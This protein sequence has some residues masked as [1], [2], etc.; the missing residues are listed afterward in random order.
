MHIPD[1]YLGPATYGSF[2]AVMVPVWGY[3]SKKV[4]AQLPSDRIPHLAM[5]SVF[6]LLAMTFAIPVPGGTTTHLQGA[7]LV[8]ILLGPW[9]AVIAVSVALAIQ[10]LL[11]GDGGV[12]VL[13]ANCFNMALVGSLCAAATFRVLQAIAKKLPM[14]D[15]RRAEAVLAALAAYLSINLSALLTAF[16]LGIQPRLHPGYFPYSLKIVIPTMM[17][18]HLSVVGILEAAMTGLS[19]QAIKRRIPPVESRSLAFLLGAFLLAASPLKAHEFWIEPGAGTYTLVFGHGSSR[20]AY[21]PANVTQAR[22]FDLEGR[23]V[24][25]RMMKKAKGVSFSATSPAALLVVEIDNKYWS[26]TIYGWKELPKR[27]ASRVVEALRSWNI[28]KALFGWGPGAMK[29][30][31]GIVL[32]LIPLE[33]PLAMKPGQ[34]LPVKVLHEGQP[35]SGVDVES[36][37]HEQAGKTDSDG[38]IRVPVIGGHQVVTVTQKSPRANDPDADWTSITTT[39]AFEVKP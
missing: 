14:K 2:W 15:H 17:V 4:G 28:S 5:A 6:C 11:F 27:K 10:A 25:V 7:A 29:P 19:F 13:A 16:E 20:S 24:D 35:L 36:T 18:T 22:G 31:P 38:V 39:L 26:K 21:D 8:A 37:G 1:G 23:P 33:N 30:I 12:T 32:D 9:A 3:A 34:T